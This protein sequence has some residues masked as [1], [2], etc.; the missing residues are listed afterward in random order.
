[1]FKTYTQIFKIE[2]GHIP[3]NAHAHVRARTHTHT[4]TRTHVV[5]NGKAGEIKR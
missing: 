5:Q 2:S 3:H 1:M 4:H